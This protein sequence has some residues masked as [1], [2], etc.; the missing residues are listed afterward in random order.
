MSFYS[1]KILLY[2]CCFN[3]SV[4]AVGVAVG[5]PTGFIIILQAAI[6]IVVLVR[7]SSGTE[8][9]ENRAQVNTEYEEMGLAPTSSQNQGATQDLPVQSA[10]YEEVG[11]TPTSSQNQGV[12][13]DVLVQST[14]Y[15]T[16]SPQATSDNHAYEKVIKQTEQVC[17]ENTSTVRN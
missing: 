14:E 3:N 16:S 6:L 7:R 2:T 8:S 5:V 13:Q 17:Y 9:G 11:L 10:E 15:E 1:N 4:W 12:T